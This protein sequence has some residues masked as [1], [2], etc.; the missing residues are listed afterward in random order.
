M[1]K[2]EKQMATQTNAKTNKTKKTTT[3]NQAQSTAQVAQATVNTETPTPVYGHVS[4]CIRLRVREKP[5]KNAE[6]V[7][8]INIG[9]KL[10]ID[11]NK[12]TTNFYAVSSTDPKE[13]YSGYCMKE[14]IAL[15]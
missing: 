14:F 1:I 15:K 5:D 7:T 9:T 13:V 10:L 6:V 11:L 3:A 8:I 4:G 12:S 2:E